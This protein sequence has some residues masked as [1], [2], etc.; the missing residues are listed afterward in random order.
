M[1][2]LLADVTSVGVA[3]TVVACVVL[4]LTMVIPPSSMRKAFEEPRG[5]EVILR[6]MTPR[7]SHHA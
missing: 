1:A 2:A 4:V 7:S 3:L 6:P 5:S